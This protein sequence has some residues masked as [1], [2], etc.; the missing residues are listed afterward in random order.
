[1]EK[2][3]LDL[4]LVERGLAKSRTFAQD[5]I[6]KGTVLVKL[7][8]DFEVVLKP[9]TLVSKEVEIN[10]IQ[11]ELSRYV[12]RGGLKLEGALKHLQLNVTD[13]KCL[14]VGLSTGGFSDCLL[15]SG[16][17]KIV[18]VDV[19]RNQ[20]DPRLQNNPKLSFIDQLNARS[21]S[22]DNRLKSQIPDD[23]GFDLA[24]MDVSFISIELIFSEIFKL[25]KLNGYLL[26]L[27][28]PQFEVGPENL[29][30]SGVVKNELLFPEVQQKISKRLVDLHFKVID[31]F[32]SSIEGKDGNKEFFVFAQK[33]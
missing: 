21:M 9:S 20:L 27:V 5:L 15:Q 24:V 18:G 29:N 12:S 26:S 33:M 13:L 7:K 22:T 6:K 31:Y 32:P 28:K 11:D 30:K 2:Q 4:L 23:L 16:V 19:G 1:M 8:D 17:A 10:L 25:L 3:K 14:D